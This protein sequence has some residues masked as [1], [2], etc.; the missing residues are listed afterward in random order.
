MQIQLNGRP[1][2]IPR[3]L[4]V[5]ALIESLGLAGQP[6]VVECNESPLTP[7]GHATTLVKAGDKIEI[8]ILAAGG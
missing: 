5:A 6:V 4:T 3:Q 2:Q 7:S 1:H 8:V